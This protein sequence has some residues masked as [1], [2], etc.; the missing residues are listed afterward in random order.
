[1]P[2][3]GLGRP[4]MG[5]DIDSGVSLLCWQTL[6]GATRGRTAR[7]LKTQVPRLEDDLTY[8]L[9]RVQGCTER[10][11]WGDILHVKL[12]SAVLLGWLH[13]RLHLRAVRANP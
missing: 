5:L 13:L 3:D 2:S 9:D 6:S 7:V 8:G 4:L 1:M 11:R 10:A 12:G